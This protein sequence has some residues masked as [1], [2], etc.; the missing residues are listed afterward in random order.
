MSK[1]AV[2]LDY[3][4]VDSIVVEVLK[5]TYSNLTDDLEGRKDD[6]EKYDI[7]SSDKEEDIFKIHQY[8]NA[9]EMVLSY[10]MTHDDFEKW[11]NE[12]L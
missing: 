11:K 10:S 3:D 5:E 8:L 2:E 1:F 9:I 4:V 7:F 6:R 12:N